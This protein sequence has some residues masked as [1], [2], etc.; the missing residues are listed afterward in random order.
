M[1]ERQQDASTHQVISSVY[2]I[3][4]QALVSKTGNDETCEDAIYI[5]SSFVA[6]I[7]GATS[8]TE[9]KWNGKTGGR[10]AAL[11]L[12]DAFAHLSPDATAREAV[13]LLTSAIKRLY[14]E[15]E[16]LDIVQ[17][18]P[19]QRATACFLA[20]S[21]SRKEI[22]SVGDCQCLLNQELVQNNKDIDTITANARSLFLAAEIAQGKTIEELREHDTGR[23]FIL[24]LLA[25]QTLFQNNPAA[26]QY[27]FPVIDG[28]PV[29]DEGIFV[30]QFPTDLHTIVLASDGY[31][32]LR[33]TL[34][35]S[36][37]LL[38]E[39]LREDPL[40]FRRYRATKGMKQGNI[41][42]DDR[43]YVKLK[44]REASSGPCV[45]E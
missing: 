16:V 29:P 6:V 9:R 45:S 12:Q 36:E 39:L 18:D 5:G 15:Y 10:I 19:V 27:W 1:V 34:E 21:F 3:E 2:E 24:P 31:P 7:D 32:Y 20:V 26:G 38:Q 41:S 4:E 37:Q 40:L 23:E 14:E 8:K 25:H 43:A 28:F 33:E 44:G 17:A 22:W 35:V 13:D 30:R 11:T 42:F